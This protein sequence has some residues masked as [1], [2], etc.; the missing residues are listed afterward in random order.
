MGK[1]LRTTLGSAVGRNIKQSE[2][3]SDGMVSST[4]LTRPV[5]VM[6]INDLPSRPPHQG[7]PSQMPRHVNFMFGANKQTFEGTC[8][9]GPLGEKPKG[10]IGKGNRDVIKRLGGQTR[11]ESD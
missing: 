5:M 3:G 8:A 4:T 2:S 11:S 7:R 10:R 9:Y 1:S 6:D